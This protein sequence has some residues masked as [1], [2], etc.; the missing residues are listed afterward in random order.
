MGDIQY[1]KCIIMHPERTSKTLF[2]EKI[3]NARDISEVSIIKYVCKPLLI[4]ALTLVRVSG[5]ATAHG[6]PT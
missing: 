2:I 6:N 5:I 4:E 3:R 1:P